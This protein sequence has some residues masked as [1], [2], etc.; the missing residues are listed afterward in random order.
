[1]T[2]PAAEYTQVA[3]VSPEFFSI[4]SLQPVAGRLFSAD[5]QKPG[6][7]GAVLISYS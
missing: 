6:S 7:R 5:E 1:M 4:F 2:G 3:R